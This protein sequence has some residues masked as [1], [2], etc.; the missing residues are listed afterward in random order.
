MIPYAGHDPNES[1]RQFSMEAQA[2]DLFQSGLDTYDIAKKL[3][4]SEARVLRLVNIERS[5]L[6]HKPS[7]YGVE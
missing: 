7:P 2:Y 4:I 6:I 3:R 5:S 1:R